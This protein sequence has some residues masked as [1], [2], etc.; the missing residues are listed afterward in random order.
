M[1]DGIEIEKF[2]LHCRKNSAFLD[3]V[4]IDK[5]IISKKFSFSDKN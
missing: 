5:M 3:Y 4:H 1:F 2:E